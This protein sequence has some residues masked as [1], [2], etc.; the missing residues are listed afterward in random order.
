MTQVMEE[1]S[2]Y[3]GHFE[4]FEKNLGAGDRPWLRR[5]RKAAIARFDELGFPG[6]RHEDWKFTRLSVLAKLPFHLAEGESRSLSSPLKKLATEPGTGPRLVFVNGRF[7]KEFSSPGRLAKGVI[8]SS[9]AEA[10]VKQENLVEPRLARNARYDE[11]AL[12]A[13]NTAFLQD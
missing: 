3:L 11:H 12:T 2:L 7:A 13:L 4:E 1:K 9:L 5:S 8:L 10:I 6:P